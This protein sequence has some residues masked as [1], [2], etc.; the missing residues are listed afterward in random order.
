M[1]KYVFACMA[2][3]WCNTQC[4]AAMLKPSTWIEKFTTIFQ[5]QEP[6]EDQIFVME[7]IQKQVGLIVQFLGDLDTTHQL[8]DKNK[9]PLIKSLEDLLG[10]LI[11]L[12]DMD[13]ASLAA[14]FVAGGWYREVLIF[15]IDVKNTLDRFNSEENPKKKTKE[16]AKDGDDFYSV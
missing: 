16:L 14:A 10:N 7:Q 11:Y 13:N 3:I 15:S 1:K 5:T 4:E 6:S 8:S 12:T 9:Q 2:L